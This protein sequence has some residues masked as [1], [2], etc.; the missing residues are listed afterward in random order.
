MLVFGES[1]HDRRA[2]KRL[3]EGLRPDL[4]GKVEE[5]R[6]PLVLIKGTL[7]GT[8]RSNAAEIAQLARAACTSSDVLA[9]LA[10]QD[11]DALE[12]A[13]EEAAERIERELAA[14]KCPAMAIGVTPAWEIEA[15]WMLFPEAVGRVVR[16]WRNPDDWI[17]KDV[18]KVRDAK[19][20][21][22]KAV[23]P[24]PRPP[25]P[26]RDYHERDSIQI[27]GNIATNGLLASFEA[28]RRRT[29]GVGGSCRETRSASFER[30]RQRVLAIGRKKPSDASAPRSR[31]KTPG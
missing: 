22:A 26:P 28:G 15:W 6:R 20:K 1:E 14:A 16:G 25:S 18:G 31:S 5:R 12:P 23:Q 2:I 19:E 27:A 7:P 11:C 24:R 29:R 9:V 13:H 10:H 3:V 4:D 30:F 8:A 21:L 17:G